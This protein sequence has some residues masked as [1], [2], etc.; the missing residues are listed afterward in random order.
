MGLL[1]HFL[2]VCLGHLSYLIY[3][4]LHLHLVHRMDP[5]HLLDLENRLDRL[6]R[7]STNWTGWTDW[8]NWT[9]WTDGTSLDQLDQLVA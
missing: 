4:E 8:T 6:D 1:D 9:D 5:A 7:Q 3:L 2:L